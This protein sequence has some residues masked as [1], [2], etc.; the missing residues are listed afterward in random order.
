[1]SDSSIKKDRGSWTVR[2]IVNGTSVLYLVLWIIQ[3]LPDKTKGDHGGVAVYTMTLATILAVIFLAVT[4]FAYREKIYIT[5]KSIIGTILAVLLVWALLTAK[6]NILT[7]SLFPS[8]EVVF[9]QLLS[10]SRLPG[11]VMSSI[12]TM[13]KGYLTALVLGLVLGSLAGMSKSLGSSL[14]YITTFI[15]LIPPVVYIPYAIALLPHYDTVSVF[16][17]FMSALRA[18]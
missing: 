2:R 9:R 12:K 17:I 14:N 8:P 4:V 6:F 18:L 1:M 11:D 15:K 5:A 3:F 16:V 10:D 13:A 7:E